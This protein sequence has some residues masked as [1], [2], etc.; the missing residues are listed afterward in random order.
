MA[1][2]G[3]ARWAQGRYSDDEPMSYAKVNVLNPRGKTHQVGNADAQGR[4]AWLGDEP[5]AWRLVFDDGMGHHVEL[6]VEV[7]APSP[8]APAAGAPPAPEKQPEPASKPPVER[9]ILGIGVLF[10]LFGSLFW[11]Y[12]GKKNREGD[13]TTKQNRVVKSRK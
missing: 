4:F 1:H 12:G 9:V 11:W 10:F 3:P 8:A 13:T 7:S 5:G 2:E 6:A